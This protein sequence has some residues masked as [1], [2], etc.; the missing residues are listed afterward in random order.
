MDY[1]NYVVEEFKR[2]LNGP[3]KEKMESL[4]ASAEARVRTKLPSYHEIRKAPLYK[5]ALINNLRS[6]GFV[7][8][9]EE[10]NEKRKSD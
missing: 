9:F 4:A 7:P 8:G 5:E 6:A 2:L 10:W 1:K 3:D